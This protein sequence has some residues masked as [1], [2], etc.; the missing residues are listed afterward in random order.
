MNKGTR[1]GTGLVLLFCFL[2]AGCATVAD[3]GDGDPM[4]SPNRAFH[5]LNKTLDKA[6]VG[7]VSEAYVWITPEILRTSIGNFFSNLGTLSVVLNDLLQGKFEQ[8][9]EDAGRFIVNSTFGIGGLFD[10]ATGV[11][12]ERHNEDLGQTF[13]VW[14]AG[15]GAY[16]ELPVLGP[17][18]VRDAPDL[19][20]STYTNP[21][22]YIFQSSV[23]LPLT[24]LKLID[25]R[26]RLAGAIRLRDKSALDTYIF[27]REAYRQRRTHLI[28]DGN[29]P[30]DAFDDLAQ[31]SAKGIE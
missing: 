6:I 10:V 29:P 5:S 8:G 30:D 22:Y 23:S 4:E 13:G 27:T 14:G 24:V 20:S 12:L 21:L 17:N 31:A 9:V 2:L 7:P 19:V 3:N 26:A 16:L 1:T 18:S 28:Y 25:D 11:G 15:E